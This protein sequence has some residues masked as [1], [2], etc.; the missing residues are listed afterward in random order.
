MKLLFLDYNGVLYTSINM[1]EIDY[2]NL[3]R[4]KIIIEETGAKIVLTSSIKNY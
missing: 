1:N 2:L 3:Q 4:L